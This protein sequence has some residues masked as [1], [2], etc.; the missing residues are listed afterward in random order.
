MW[1]DGSYV[2]TTSSTVACPK[3][4][5]VWL[6]V[7]AA[8]ASWLLVVLVSVMASSFFRSSVVLASGLC[9]WAGR[10][11]GGGKEAEEGEWSLT[12]SLCAY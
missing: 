7:G 1:H 11:G 9:G 5:Y 4:W 10:L 12:A 8:V 2:L 3:S 6:A